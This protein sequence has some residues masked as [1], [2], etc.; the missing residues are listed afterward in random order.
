VIGGVSIA[1]LLSGAG[2][3]SGEERLFYFNFGGQLQA[4]AA[5]KGSLSCKS[6]NC[7]RS[8]PKQAARF[9]REL[10]A[11]KQQMMSFE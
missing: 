9:D 1:R 4:C 10:Q 11:N 6:G 7:R 3:P 2:T 5:A 8:L